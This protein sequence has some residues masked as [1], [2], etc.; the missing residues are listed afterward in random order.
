VSRRGWVAT[1]CANAWTGVL[2][3]LAVMLAVPVAQ[4]RFIRIEGTCCCPHVKR[5]QCPDHD[6][7]TARQRSI[8]PCHNAPRMSATPAMPGFEPAFGA[9]LSVPERAVAIASFELPA[10]HAPPAPRR[11]DAPS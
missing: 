11:P 3:A 9:A 1:A 10:P 2:V 5:C 8:R 4:L 7:G 6:P